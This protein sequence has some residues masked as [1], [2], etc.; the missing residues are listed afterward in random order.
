MSED[1]GADGAAA[2]HAASMAT[3]EAAHGVHAS[4]QD[5]LAKLP[6]RQA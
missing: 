6:N 5:V 1:S 4:T 3:E 2:T